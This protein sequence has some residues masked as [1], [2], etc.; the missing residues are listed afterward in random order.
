MRRWINIL[1]FFAWCYLVLYLIELQIV[2]HRNYTI[3]AKSQHEQKVTLV[4]KRGN[5]YDRKGRPLAI[6]LKAYSI[7]AVTRYV[8]NQKRTA[9]KLAQLRLRSYRKI[10]S[11]LRRKKFFWVKKKVSEDIATK[12]KDLNLPGIGVIEDYLRVYPQ[13]DCLK[14]LIGIVSCDNRGLAGIEFQ[15]DSLLRGEDGF[16]IFQKKPSGRGYPY[17]HYPMLEPRPGADLYLT[18]DLDLQI[19]LYDIL[20]DARDKYRSGKTG[21]I[22]IDPQSGKILAMVNVNGGSCHNS[23]A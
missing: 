1:P 6:S 8:K 5:I 9:M 12:I 18:I 21:G 16:A 19:L 7:Y 23:V 20:K 22:I 10:Q 14:N 2:K 4:A 13:G 3:K 11:L 15:F 17:P